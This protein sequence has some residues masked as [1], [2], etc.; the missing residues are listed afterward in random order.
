MKRFFITM[1][2]LVGG[3]T[4]AAMAQIPIDATPVDT[5]KPVPADTIISYGSGGVTAYP[6]GSVD[7][8]PNPGEQLCAKIIK[9]PGG[10]RE[11]IAYGS[12]GIRELPDG[13]TIYCPNPGDTRCGRVVVQP[14]VITPGM[15]IMREAD[16][17]LARIYD[18]DGRV[19]N[20]RTGNG[21]IR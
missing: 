7:Y 8:C 11:V 12:G 21:A 5:I 14:R 1:M 3:M 2:L 13:T 16:P 18:M 17:A 15:M 20:A 4:T 10:G 19:V 6:D 9:N